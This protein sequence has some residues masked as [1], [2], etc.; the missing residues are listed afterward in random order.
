MPLL[1]VADSHH[2]AE[3]EL[4]AIRTTAALTLNELDT[5]ILAGALA[6]QATSLF[7]CERAMIAVLEGAEPIYRV[8]FQDGGLTQDFQLELGRD[9]S[10]GN[11]AMRHQQ[12]Y[13]SN[14]PVIGTSSGPTF[15]LSRSCRNLL[16]VPIL[17]HQRTLIGIIEAHNRQDRALINP[18][19]VR[20]AEVFS[21]QAAVGLERARLY[22][23]L[24]DWSQSLEM[25]LGFN[26]AVNQHLT[27]QALIRRL[28]ENAIRF[29]KADGG[30][31][32][33]AVP[34][35]QHDGLCM[36]SEGYLHK[37]TWH[38]RLQRWPRMSGLPGVVLESEFP[39]LMNDYRDDRNADPQL[40]Q[41]FG[42]SRAL[43]VPIKNAKDE[44][45]GFFELH[46]SS[47]GLPFT[48][49]D[50]AFLESLGSTTAVAIENAQLLKALERKNLQI[51]ALSA[52][53]V[54]RLEEERQHVARELHDEAGQAL[55]GIKLS[56]QVVAKQI[57]PEMS[58]LRD[59]LDR[60][61][62]QVNQATGRLKDLARGL[63]PAT[64]DQLGIEIALGQLGSEF[65]RL[66]SVKVELDIDRLDPPP[67]QDCATAIYRIAQ[68]AI[69][70]T[71]RYA[72]AKLVRLALWR[73]AG[74]LLFEFEDDGKGFEMKQ[75][76]QG[77]GLLGMRERARILGAKIDISSRL[78]SG[79]RIT[80]E[81]TE[82]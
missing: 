70:N 7:H 20:L 16:T 44:V 59:E 29:L 30:Q 69:T 51:R 58:S 25:L 4:Q 75:S 82:S 18:N 21:W 65:E 15:A 62:E 79:T 19:D 14:A 61:R 10:A 48:W 9:K 5:R 13:F 26:A 80:L 53:N 33:L 39:Y 56:L 64:L 67:S 73:D 72:E 78:G 27:P 23:R 45:L 60:L 41:E 38:E 40:M 24:N 34:T 54:Q 81:V 11:T 42:I 77:L 63:R 37:S 28:V 12:S 76:T 1:A 22:D 32:G 49:Q 43:C 2:L 17:N 6:K 35:D 52:H 31:A 8:A 74:L 50:A 36:E 55:I 46:K 3:G 66:S 71:G 57:P 47:E 68:E